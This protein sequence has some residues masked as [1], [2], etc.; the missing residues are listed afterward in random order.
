MKKNFTLIELLVV[1]AIIAILAG[2]LLPALNNARAR[3][4]AIN[5][6]SNLKQMIQGAL[7]YAD[8]NQG[9]CVNNSSGTTVING[10][11]AKVLSGDR[12]TKTPAYLDFNICY[13]P[14]AKGEGGTPR[15]LAATYGWLYAPGTLGTKLIDVFGNFLAT[16]SGTSAPGAWNNFFYNLN[17][18]RDYAELP[19]VMDTY[20]TAQNYH[21]YYQ[22]APDNSGYNF[23]LA[24]GN[25]GNLGFADGHVAAWS[26]N[27]YRL[28]KLTP[29]YI[30]TTDDQV[31]PL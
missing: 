15:D 24:H 31:F 20:S 14:N 18:I 2:M 26:L 12:N 27:E 1:I 22:C 19:L 16:S 8:D 5:C 17:N 11:A 6:T 3:A 4:R 7:F 13:C 29:K 10:N 9:F 30:F 28:S 21:S 25:T 23:Y